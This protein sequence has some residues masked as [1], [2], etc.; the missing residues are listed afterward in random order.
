MIETSYSYTESNAKIIEK[1][2]DDDPVQINHIILATN[3][4]LPEHKASSNVY[5]V[6]VRGIMTIQL[7][8]QEAHTYH[9]G[10]IVNIPCQAKMNI[11]NMHD[12]VLEF[13]VVKS[14]NPRHY[15]F[16][17]AGIQAVKK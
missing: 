7:A 15:D 2:I 5:L 14:P 11:G 3:D 1:L 16:F 6:V 12:E 8:E 4:W 10:H 17:T 9:Q 13:F